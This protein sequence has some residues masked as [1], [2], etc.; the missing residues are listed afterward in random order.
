MLLIVLIESFFGPHRLLKAQYSFLSV[1]FS[2]E[3]KFPVQ[4]ILTGW[5]ESELPRGFSIAILKTGSV[6][7][8]W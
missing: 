4:W 6:H 1:C 2:H 8:S 7:L 5:P 3:Y